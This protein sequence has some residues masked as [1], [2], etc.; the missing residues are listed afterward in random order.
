MDLKKAFEKSMY[1]KIKNFDMYT[2]IPKNGVSNDELLRQL[3]EWSKYEDTMW[4]GEQKYVSGTV[5]HGGKD[6]IELQNK[7]Y[8]M[9]SVSNPL[10]PS[11]FPFVRKM[12]A[13]I[14]AMTISYFNGN[15]YKECGMLTSGGT[16]SIIM[17]IRAYWMYGKYNKNIKNPELIMSNT[18]HAAFIKA[19]DMFNIKCVIVKP[20]VK[21]FRLG[22]NNVEGYINRNTIAIVGSCPDYSHGIQDDIVGL[23][24]LA[25]KYDIGF[26]VDCCIGSYLLPTIKNIP[27]YGKNIIDFD[28]GVDGIGSI[29][30]DTHKYGYTVKGTSVLMFKNRELR[31]YAYFLTPQSNIGLYCTPT[32]QGSRSGGNIVA[33]WTTLMHM[34][35]DGYK[36]DAIKIMNAVDI[37]KHGIKTKLSKYITILGDPVSSI[38]SWTSNIKGIHV[39]SFSDAMKQKGWILNNC[40]SPACTHIAVTRANCNV[41]HKF[42][43][44][45][46]E[47]CQNVVNNPEIYRTKGG[48]IYGTMIQTNNKSNLDEFM[49]TYLDVLLDLPKQ[50]SKL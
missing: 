48:A 10:H 14:V 19:C 28:W 20:D 24:K 42:V 21:T 3:N 44:D 49:N 31:R 13:E 38:V 43:N 25:K 29:S 18:G 15:P 16:E 47:C 32:I 35:Q 8:S 11:E 17:G 50:H 9:F 22:V 37:I 7:A 45:M 39:Y 26:H 34:G 6:L 12:M 40:K 33:A 30:V 46:L 23:A 1:A 27:K 5:Y 2:E 36:K 4:N 41:A